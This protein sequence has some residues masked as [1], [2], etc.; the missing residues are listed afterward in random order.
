MREHTPLA[1]VTFD[2]DHFK[3]VND[4]H[5]HEVGDRVLQWVAKTLAHETRGADVTAR[6]GGEEFVVLLPGTGATGAVELAERVR[7]S[8]ERGGGPVPITISAGVASQTPRG[9]DHGLVEAADRALYRAKGDG[10][11]A[12]RLADSE[13]AAL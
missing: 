5:G 12:V 3:R 8:V 2:L 7:A 6:V 1:V 11:N 9:P 13:P 4:E 10:R